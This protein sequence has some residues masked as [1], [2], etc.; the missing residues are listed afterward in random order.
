[1]RKVIMFNSVSADGFFAGPKGELHE[2]TIN[3]PK[4]TK[5]AHKMMRPDTVLFGRTTYKMFEGFWP[6]VSENPKA[7]KGEKQLAKELKNMNKLVFSK[8][9][10]QVNW[11]N[12]TLFRGDL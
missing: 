5:A 4:V 8:T 1:M 10:K 12:T 11:K 7:A 3:D 2:W 9:L 6:K